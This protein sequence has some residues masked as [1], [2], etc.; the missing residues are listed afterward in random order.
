MLIKFSSESCLVV[1]LVR[2]QLYGLGPRARARDRSSSE[3]LFIATTSDVKS[4]LNDG[5]VDQNTVQ[6]DNV[7]KVIEHL[8]KCFAFVQL[9]SVFYFIQPFCHSIFDLFKFQHSGKIIL[10]W[11]KVWIEIRLVSFFARSPIIVDI[12]HVWQSQPFLPLTFLMTPFLFCFFAERG[13]ELKLHFL[14]PWWWWSSCWHDQIVTGNLRHFWENL[15]ILYLI[16][17]RAL[18]KKIINLSNGA[19]AG[20]YGS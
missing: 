18:V 4:W 8:K 19:W 11:Q 17:D 2:A 5:T 16:G 15:L 1:F 6:W 9:E 3:K 7:E 20:L 14:W 10:K 12:F 13:F